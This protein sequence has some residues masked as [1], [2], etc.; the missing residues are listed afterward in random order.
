MQA[1]WPVPRMLG[2]MSV[3]NLIFNRAIGSMLPPYYADSKAAQATRRAFGPVRA[4]SAAAL[5]WDWEAAVVLVCDRARKG[6]WANSA[7]HAVACRKPSSLV[8]S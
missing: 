1:H 7:C 3:R 8:C 5:A 6:A 4:L 2:S